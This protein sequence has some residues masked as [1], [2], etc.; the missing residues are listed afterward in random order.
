VS[1]RRAL[2]DLMTT[3]TQRYPHV[4]NAYGFGVRAAAVVAHLAGRPGDA[5]MLLGGSRIH[6]IDFRYEGGLALGCL[7]GDRCREMVSQAAAKEAT[8]RG[9][10]LSIDELIAL[11]NRTAKPSE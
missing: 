7:Y 1:A 10:G 4:E 5:L 9:E 8:V 3:T 6:H 2:A 11:A